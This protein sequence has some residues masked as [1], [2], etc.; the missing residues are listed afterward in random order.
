V[1]QLKRFSVCRLLLPGCIQKNP[2]H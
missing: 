2:A 1:P